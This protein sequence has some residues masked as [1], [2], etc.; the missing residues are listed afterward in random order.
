MALLA[1]MAAGLSRG[2]LLL[3]AA[4]THRSAPESEAIN[5]DKAKQERFILKVLLDGFHG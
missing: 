5:I 3:L 2:L 1:A 4:S